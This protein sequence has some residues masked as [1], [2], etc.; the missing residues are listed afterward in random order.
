MLFG[1]WD[2][3]FVVIEPGESFTL[4]QFMPME[5]VRHEPGN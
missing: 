3:D 5:K 4:E 1:P 2:E